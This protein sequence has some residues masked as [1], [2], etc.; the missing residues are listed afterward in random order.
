MSYHRANRI[1]QGN[2]PV[3]RLNQEAFERIKDCARPPFVSTTLDD[4][5]DDRVVTATAEGKDR[6]PSAT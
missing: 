6:A 4:L 5:Q 3:V 2:Q 1:R